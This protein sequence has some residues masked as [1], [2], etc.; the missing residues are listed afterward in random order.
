MAKREGEDMRALKNLGSM[1]AAFAGISL[2]AACV[3]TTAGVY[4]TD[5]DFAQPKVLSGDWQ[6]VPTADDPEAFKVRLEVKGKLI[7]AQPLTETGEIDTNEEPIDFGVVPL[8]AGRYIVA[9][10]EDEG[11]VSYLGLE[12]E[13]GKLAFYFFDG[14]DSEDTEAAFKDL[15]VDL[16]ISRDASLTS[17]LRLTGKNLSADKIKALFSALLDNPKKYEA[18][19]NEYVSMK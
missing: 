1:I 3:I 14:G 10:T 16:E 6:K 7:R 8:E 4:F 5:A 2:L 13:E 17:E 9:H 11:S 19:V 18:Y 12:A 15:L